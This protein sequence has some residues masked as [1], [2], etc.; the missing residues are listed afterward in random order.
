MRLNEGVFFRQEKLMVHISK[1]LKDVPKALAIWKR[2]QL[3][4]P[5][6]GSS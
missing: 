6:L 2:I 1:L 4:P 5:L 3:L